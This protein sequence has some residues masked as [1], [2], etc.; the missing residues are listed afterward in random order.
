MK[1]RGLKRVLAAVF[2]I[3]MVFALAACGNGGANTP[4][5]EAPAA[6]DTGSQDAAAPAGSSGAYTIGYLN[7][8]PDWIL[9]EY[10]AE[11]KEVALWANPD[12]EWLEADGGYMADQM[13]TKIQ[14]LLASG[15]EALCYDAHFETMLTDTVDKCKQ[16]DAALLI[17]HIPTFPERYDEI[18]AYDKFVGYFGSDLYQAGYQLGQRAAADGGKIAIIASG[19]KGTIDMN[20]KIDGFT[21]GFEDG[22]GTIAQL[23]TSTLPPEVEGLV[24]G[25]LANHPDCDTIYGTTGAHTTSSLSA[26]E[27]AGLKDKINFYSSDLGPELIQM[28]IDGDVKAGDAG[29]TVEW[30][31]GMTLLINFLD[32]HP[33][34]DDSGRQPIIDWM[35]PLLV[36]QG[37]AADVKATWFDKHP[38][39]EGLAKHFLWAYNPDISY[40][41]YTDFA[42]SYSVD[43]YT[44]LQKQ[45]S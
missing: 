44:N 41:D 12:N 29:S 10:M 39:T 25:A 28:V 43:W 21:A 18:R 36:D 32:G 40:T 4:A 35:K 17:A 6:A 23:I 7:F 8:G 33:I 37:N 30:A 38:V 11:A 26:A 19:A 2:C 45:Y 5:E 14:E 27:K 16:A 20:G 22:G 34:V 9:N 3:M 42:D 31:L 15:A 13:T 1:K 24:S